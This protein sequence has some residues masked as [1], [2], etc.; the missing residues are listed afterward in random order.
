M[1]INVCVKSYN[2]VERQQ[3]QHIMGFYVDVLAVRL[4]MLMNPALYAHRGKLV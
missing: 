1:H 3:I 4:A 2:K